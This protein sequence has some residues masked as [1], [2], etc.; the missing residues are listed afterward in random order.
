MGDTILSAKEGVFYILLWQFSMIM[1]Q[2]FIVVFIPFLDLGE[3][4]SE[5]DVMN[6][7]Q[8]SECRN[9]LIRCKAPYIITQNNRECKIGEVQT[10]DCIITLRKKGRSSFN[11]WR[12]WGRVSKKILNKP[13]RVD[14]C[15]TAPNLRQNAVSLSYQ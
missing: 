13:Q 4:C 14:N 7:I 2:N 11:S 15:A 1:K 10:T 3:S 12:G 6:Y 5:A 8:Y 9:G